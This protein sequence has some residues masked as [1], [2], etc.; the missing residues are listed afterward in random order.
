MQRA[1]RGELAELRSKLQQAN[2]ERDDKKTL[3][4]IQK[5]VSYMTMGIDMTR[6]FPEMIIASNT[7]NLVQKKLVYLYLCTY[8]EAQ[9]ELSLL[10]VNTLQK[11][12]SD[13]SPMVRG[14][15]LRSMASLRVV[16]IVEYL[17]PLVTNGLSDISAYV[18]KTAVMAAAKLYSVTPDVFISSGL[19]DK[20]YK[21]LRDS[22]PQVIINSLRVLKEILADSGG[23]QIPKELL[24]YL[25]NRLKEFNEWGQCAVIDL[26]L[27][28]ELAQEEVVNV[29]NLLDDKLKHTNSAIVLAVCSVFLKLTEGYP[30]IHDAVYSRI[31][32][33]LLLSMETATLPEIMYPILCHLKLLLSRH[34]ELLDEDYKIFYI[35]INDPTY[36][37]L[38]KIELVTQIVNDKTGSNILEELLAYATDVDIQTAKKALHAIGMICIK[39]PSIVSKAL[40]KLL[41][42]LDLQI[43]YISA[44]TVMV[45]KDIIRKY[46]TTSEDVID[47]IEPCIQFISEP[48]AKAA[49]IWM[50]GEY[51]DKVEESPYILEN[52]CES[53][54]DMDSHV[55][56]QLLV[57]A[58]KV[59][60]KRPQECQPVLGQI[61]KTAIN[62]SSSVDVHDRALLYFRL[63]QQDV[64][65]AARVIA[66]T[67]VP[68]SFFSEDVKPEIYDRL[69]EEF[70]T[71]SV[72]YE[73]PS[74]AFI[75]EKPKV[76][77]SSVSLAPSITQKVEHVEPPPLQKFAT[78][79]N[80]T[81]SMTTVEFQKLWESCTITSTIEK[82]WSTPVDKVIAALKSN[83]YPITCMASG[84]VGDTAKIYAYAKTDN[85][86]F[87]VEIVIKLKHNSP[88]S[89]VATVK[90]KDAALGKQFATFFEEVLLRDLC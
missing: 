41:D 59:F 37:K 62:D 80:D 44:S 15:A 5:I 25:L 30:Q 78:T 39:I 28:A 13:S 12:C 49:A 3:T 26:L 19:I 64:T 23:P 82:P 40:S 21:L 73:K 79:L 68:I 69:F 85:L 87:L 33:P 6:V 90:S 81:P 75:R 47:R 11:D 56:L 54:K 55:K 10:G 65:E 36:I 24:F 27:L 61:L 58:V 42:L 9:P 74:E 70:N 22:D 7:R 86:A 72:L 46:P 31:K 89:L 1:K 43:D 77:Q 16:N 50:L 60:F 57:A 45:I 63:L 83:T 34:P 51:G 67:K 35:H 2:N 88:H 53:W 66:P 29:L 14:L 71:L 84:V 17:F 8:A 18:R 48:E 20:L 76:S 32:G 52:L 4:L 38:L